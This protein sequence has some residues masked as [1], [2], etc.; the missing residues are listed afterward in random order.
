M[1]PESSTSVIAAFRRNI[2]KACRPKASWRT[3]AVLMLVAAGLCFEATGGIAPAEAGNKNGHRFTVE[4]RMKVW[5]KF[6]AY[7]KDDEG[8]IAS[9]PA[10]E[11][12]V[13]AGQTGTLYCHTSGSCKFGMYDTAPAYASHGNL[14]PDAPARTIEVTAGRVVVY[15]IDSFVVTN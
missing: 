6:A 11:T 5:G 9:V 15:S 1:I 10:S 13:Q 8:Q 12:I 7:N 4:N 3:A 2:T 14:F